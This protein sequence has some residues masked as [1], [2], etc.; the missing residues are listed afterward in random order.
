MIEMI[1]IVNL[2]NAQKCAVFSNASIPSTPEYKDMQCVLLM[3]LTCALNCFL[4]FVFLRGW[5]SEGSKEPPRFSSGGGHEISF[6]ST[7]QQYVQ[8]VTMPSIR[9]AAYSAA[10]QYVPS[11]YSYVLRVVPYI[12]VVSSM[13]STLQN[14]VNSSV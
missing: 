2:P 13:C 9:V 7:A 1:S 12:S 11:I 10:Q 5:W 4:L 8:Y 3:V 6:I 14:S